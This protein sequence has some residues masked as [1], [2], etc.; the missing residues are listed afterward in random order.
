M[1]WKHEFSNIE[2]VHR[3][4]VVLTEKLPTHERVCES[5]LSVASVAGEALGNVAANPQVKPVRKTQLHAA[6]CSL[7]LFDLKS[8]RNANNL[9]VVKRQRLDLDIAQWGISEFSFRMNVTTVHRVS[10]KILV[11]WQVPVADSIFHTL[12]GVARK[13]G[14]MV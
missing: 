10:M 6:R 8:S 12:F 1:R 11:S 3:P 4:V 2:T 9:N 5:S 7:E 13:Y 14:S